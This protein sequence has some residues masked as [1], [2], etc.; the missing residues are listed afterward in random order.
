MVVTGNF[1]GWTQKGGI[2]SKKHSSEPFT[3]EIRV[4][5]KSKLVFKFVVDGTW[6]T[7]GEFKSETDEHGNLNNYINAEELTSVEEFVQEPETT[8]PPV[9]APVETPDEPEIAEVSVDRAGES[10]IADAPVDTSDEPEKFRTSVDTAAQPEIVQVPVETPDVPEILEAPVGTPGQPEIVVTLANKPDE[11]NIIEVPQERPVEQEIFQTRVET[12]EPE[13][14]EV[15][16][17]EP[18][19]ATQMHATAEA[20]ITESES[21]DEWFTRALNASSYATVSVASRD[22]AF[23]HVS[24]DNDPSNRNATEEIT[25]TNTHEDKTGAKSGPTQSDS[26]VTTIGPNSRNNSISGGLHNSGEGENLEKS[27]KSASLCDWERTRRRDGF[28]FRL[29]GLFRS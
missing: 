1:D 4:P 16:T 11:L 27:Y 23:E 2:L 5:S 17:K 3:G 19:K 7:S 18:K 15:D 25:P 21:E 14:I 13:I 29:R 8:D 26:E 9:K 10:E 6:T 20:K 24:Q 12:P 28:M 22:S